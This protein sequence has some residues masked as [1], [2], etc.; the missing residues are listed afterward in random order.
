MEIEKTG[1]FGEKTIQNSKADSDINSLSP[2]NSSAPYS[3]SLGTSTDQ[4]H[5]ENYSSQTALVGNNLNPILSMNS[6]GGV[7][8]ADSIPAVLGGCAF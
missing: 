2:F 6:V 8:N 3:A 5:Q 4:E 7:S 1:D